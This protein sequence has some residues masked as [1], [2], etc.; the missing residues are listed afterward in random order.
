M[1]MFNNEEER[2]N[3]INYRKKSIVLDICARGFDY[4]YQEF[5]PDDL[6]DEALFENC[7][8]AVMAVMLKAVNFSEP[9]DKYLLGENINEPILH[10]GLRTKIYYEAER[11]NSK[12]SSFAKENG[13]YRYIIIRLKYFFNTYIKAQLHIVSYDDEKELED[14]YYDLC[15]RGFTNYINSEVE[16]YDFNYLEIFN[17]NYL[18]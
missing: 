11:V 17:D 15:K 6:Y 14:I 18:C 9:F 12:L 10:E 5:K 8:T 16:E 7:I 2:K 1:G 13:F 3:K 4:I